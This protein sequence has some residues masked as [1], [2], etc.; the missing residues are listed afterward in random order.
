M[1]FSTVLPDPAAF[2]A[3]SRLAQKEKGTLILGQL[4]PGR[5]EV[6]R[7]GFFWR[8]LDQLFDL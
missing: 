6:R 8:L 3:E 7:N 1:T 2:I 4:G 5:P